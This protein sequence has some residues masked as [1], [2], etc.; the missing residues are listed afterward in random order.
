MAWSVP[1]PLLNVSVSLPAPPSISVAL[2]KAPPSKTSASAPAPR[3]TFPV[4]AAP[5]FT[6]TEVFPADPMIAFRLPEPTD[7]PLRR[8]M[9]TTLPLPTSVLMAATPVPEPPVTVPKTER[10]VLPLPLRS[11]KIPSPDPPAIWP[12]AWM[13]TS[14]V[15]LESATMPLRA[16]DAFTALA[17][18]IEIPV[19]LAS[20]YARS[21]SPEP[22]VTDPFTLREIEPPPVLRA[23]TPSVAP[24]IS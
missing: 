13:V 18:L 4:I 24:L 20:S 5:V 15:P 3:R 9:P 22:P 6:V 10:R 23:T 16:P 2:P 12:E 11:T 21:P 19:P 14:P 17:T 8:D 7:A 1:D